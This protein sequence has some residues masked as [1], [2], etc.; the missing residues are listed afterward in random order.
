[1]FLFCS[2]FR[3]SQTIFRALVLGSI[4]S[5]IV[6]TLIS[7]LSVALVVFIIYHGSIGGGCVGDSAAA[8]LGD[9]APPTD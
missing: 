7:L 6:L 4:L 3:W 9:S 2:F 1:M 5:R 8:T